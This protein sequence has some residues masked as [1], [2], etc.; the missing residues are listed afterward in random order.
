MCFPF[1]TFPDAD[2]DLFLVYHCV[3]GLAGGELDVGWLIVC[4]V[5]RSLDKEICLD[6]QTLGITW[7][8]WTLKEICDLMGLCLGNVLVCVFIVR[9]RGTQIFSDQKGR[10]FQSWVLVATYFFIPLRHMDQIILPGQHE[11]ALANETSA[12]FC[13]SLRDGQF[14]YQA[15]CQALFYSLP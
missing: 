9:G 4:L 3:L 8:S 2:G 7:R 12:E 13:L 6:E 11:V 5:H 10:L 14:P 1:L 15:V